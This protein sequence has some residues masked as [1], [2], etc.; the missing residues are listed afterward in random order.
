MDDTLDARASWAIADIED[1]LKR[2]P[3]INPDGDD[4]AAQITAR[5]KL[6]EELAGW[7]RRTHRGSLKR[8]KKGVA[9]MMLGVTSPS[10][11]HISDACKSWVRCARL[12]IR[13]DGQ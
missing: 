10:K 1:W 3:A 4:L 8:S 13:R 6:E 12:K 11:A 2:L 9:L 7:L 5:R